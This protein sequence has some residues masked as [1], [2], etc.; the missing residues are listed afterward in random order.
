M[1]ARRVPLIA[2]ALA[3]AP[4]APAHA[5]LV[6]TVPAAPIAPPTYHRF[7]DR[8]AAA[9]A[10]TGKG[11]P[12]RALLV[13]VDDYASPALPDLAGARNDVQALAATLRARGASVD[14]RT[15]VDRA[16]LIAA[17]DRLVTDTGC[18][19]FVFFHFSGSSAPQALPGA[20]R[21]VV[22]M[23]RDVDPARIDTDVQGLAGAE[24]AEAVIAMRNRG[25]FVF[26][27]LDGCHADG[28]DFAGVRHRATWRWAP[29]D[30]R[31]PGRLA[32]RPD[33]GGFAAFFASDAN[34]ITL[35][36]N[37]PNGPPMGAYSRAL[38]AAL[39]DRSVASF[40]ELATATARIMASFHPKARPVF[41]TSDPDAPLFSAPKSTATAIEILS[42][43][44]SGAGTALLADGP[45][46][47]L[48]GR[49]VPHQ[50]LDRVWVRG[51]EARLLGDGRFRADSELGEGLARLDVIAAFHDHRFVRTEVE[52]AV[53]ADLA[54]ATR[55]TRYALV[56]GNQ[57]YAS[58]SAWTPLSTPHADAR[59]IA[60]LLRERF[61]FVTELTVPGLPPRPLLV[62]DG[63]REDILGTLETV[64][65]QLL[66]DDTLLVYFAGH[67][68]H[69]A[70]TGQSYWIPI[71]A[72]DA[73]YTWIPSTDLLDQFKV[74]HA[75]HVLV[76]SDSCFS[77]GLLRAAAPAAPR[78]G[79]RH[80]QLAQLAARRSRAV[81]TSGGNEPVAD[82]GGDGHSVFA[83]ALLGALERAARPTTMREVFTVLS[84]E[85]AG[86]G[87]QTPALRSFGLGDDGGDVVL[88][89]RAD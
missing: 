40:R 66:P 20:A 49:V 82:D 28:V 77:G 54:P 2:L 24:L 73:R 88:V 67:G 23:T 70:A 33:A 13:G 32:L 83:R 50:G 22:L 36:S 80:I 63:T 81:L 53:G 64:G 44:R 61:G 5:G 79:A 52:I 42:P 55:G 75:N 30:A 15:D 19:D 47:T 37:D 21:D 14:A 72:S 45:R 43:R 69:D 39:A 38:V 1:S 27:S 3:L 48:E 68:H 17:L 51:A 16:T 11:G 6:V 8:P 7:P 60:A 65:Q 18:G 56:I 4:L 41:E 78:S 57:H 84:T 35:E 31:A 46:V 85:V 86:R 74:V 10:C 89:P 59:A 29:G 26:T 25:A 76:I 58:G 71:G 12:L 34:S 9:P 87:G 62:L